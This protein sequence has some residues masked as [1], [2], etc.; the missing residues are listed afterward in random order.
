[1]NMRARAPTHTT[2][3]CTTHARHQKAEKTK[4]RMSKICYISG[5]ALIV[6]CTARLRG[7]LKLTEL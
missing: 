1:M 5:S 3:A 7:K 6:K 2:H 4:L